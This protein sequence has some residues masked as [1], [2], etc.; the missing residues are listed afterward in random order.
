MTN[1]VWKGF[2]SGVGSGEAVGYIEFTVKMIDEFA[3]E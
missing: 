2:D 1:V 3:S